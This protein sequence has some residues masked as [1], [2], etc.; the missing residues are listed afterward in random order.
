MQDEFW[1]IL[2]MDKR[3]VDDEPFDGRPKNAE[4]GWS[5]LIKMGGVGSV[6]WVGCWSPL[7]RFIVDPER[8]CR[9]S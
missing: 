3:I 7:R 2:I 5:E 4:G 1:L 6:G 9:R 8:R